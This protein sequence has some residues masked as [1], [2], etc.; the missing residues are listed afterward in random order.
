MRLLSI[1]LSSLLVSCDAPVNITPSPHNFVE[2]CE[3]ENIL[4]RE[5]KLEP[6]PSRV[7][8]GTVKEYVVDRPND[9]NV[10]FEDPSSNPN[11]AFNISYSPRLLENGTVFIDSEMLLCRDDDVEI[12][13]YN[14]N[15]CGELKD[16]HENFL[17]FL[18]HVNLRVR[19]DITT[20]RCAFI[21]PR[22][23]ILSQV[24]NNGQN[25]KDQKPVFISLK[26]DR[27][28]LGCYAHFYD[29]FNRNL[30]D[31]LLGKE[32]IKLGTSSGRE[33]DLSTLRRQPYFH[34]KRDLNHR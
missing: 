18:E 31:T 10:L 8:K 21:W 9:Y 13:E 23:F 3:I 14:K 1:I 15:E 12:S 19:C 11:F 5:Y 7:I 26:F 2:P 28:Y 6:I 32:T 34:Y 27:E 24:N 20:E 29:F 17:V 16:K 33:Y 22:G 4:E 30:D 25:L